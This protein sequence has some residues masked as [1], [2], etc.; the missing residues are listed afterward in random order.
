MTSGPALGR[1]VAQSQQRKDSELGVGG[2][3]QELGV[4]VSS[5]VPGAPENWGPL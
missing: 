4:S 1:E 2:S 5:S 3:P